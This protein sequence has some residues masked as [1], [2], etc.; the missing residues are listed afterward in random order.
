MH[1]ARPKTINLSVHALLTSLEIQ[2]LYAEG[3]H[4]RAIQIITALMDL[5]ATE[6]FAIHLVEGSAFLGVMMNKRSILSL[7]SYCSL[8]INNCY[9]FVS[10]DNICLSNE[11]CIRGICRVV[12]NSDEACNEGHICE[13]RICK[14]GCRDDNACD[15][16]QACLNGQCKGETR[17]R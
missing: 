16:D 13:N 3:Y 2:N 15:E 14:Q 9:V 6:I 7:P 4:R 10:S 12:C 17:L 11:K 8:N 1:Y 5:V